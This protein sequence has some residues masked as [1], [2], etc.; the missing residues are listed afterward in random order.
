[1]VCTLLCLFDMP[2]TLGPLSVIPSPIPTPPRICC[3]TILSLLSFSLA[4]CPPSPL[5]PLARF[6]GPRSLCRPFPSYPSPSFRNAPPP[7]SHPT[8]SHHP[9]THSFLSL[10]PPP[11]DPYLPALSS[12]T[13]AH[14]PL[15]SLLLAPSPPVSPLP[16]PAPPEASPFAHLAIRCVALNRQE[17]PE[18]RGDVLQGLLQ[19]AERARLFPKNAAPQRLHSFAGSG[20]DQPP[21][22][23]ICPITQVGVNGVQGLRS[24]RK[25]RG[26]TCG[27]MCWRKDGEGWGVGGGRGGQ[28]VCLSTLPGLLSTG[29][30]RNE[31]SLRPW[32]GVVPVRVDYT[33][34][35]LVAQHHWG[36]LHVDWIHF[37][38]FIVSMLP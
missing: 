33:T 3:S 32:L 21:S 23:F 22:M 31:E 16:P 8:L 37:R 28:V 11:S 30:K 27:L 24:S 5:F 2:V 7:P 9:P 36:T 29:W 1:M 4:F 18:L 13:F 38:W 15:L 20:V 10:A 34:P 19:L 26:C 35:S 17:R 12:L 6:P 14:Y 25:G